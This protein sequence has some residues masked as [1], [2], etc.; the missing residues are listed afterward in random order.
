[1]DSEDFKLLS[2]YNAINFRNVYSNSKNN[3]MSN[4]AGHAIKS[5]L[6]KPA[7]IQTYQTTSF[8]FF[9]VFFILFSGLLFFSAR[10][11]ITLYILLYNIVEI[12]YYMTCQ[13]ITIYDK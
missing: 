2:D 11:A 12:C 8:F 1:M 6:A 3:R 5:S 7:K 10:E 4:L 9:N 13:C